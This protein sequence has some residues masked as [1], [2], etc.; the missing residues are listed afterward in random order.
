[1]SRIMETEGELSAEL[2]FFNY[3]L[4]HQISEH[5]DFGRQSLER[6]SRLVQKVAIVV[7]YGLISAPYDE[8]GN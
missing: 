1:M 5:C 2:D 7:N 3:F 8:V 4:G 6:L